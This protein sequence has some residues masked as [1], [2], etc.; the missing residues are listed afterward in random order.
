MNV[1]STSEAGGRPRLRLEHIADWDARIVDAKYSPKE[2]C[3]QCG[4]SMRHMQRFMM[5][6]FKIGL[7]AFVNAL[8][9]SKAHNLLKAG[10]SIK[11]TAIGLG[12]KQTSHF[13]R[14][15]KQHFAAKAST[16]LLNAK[17]PGA[18]NDGQMELDFL[19]ATPQP[20]RRKKAPAKKTK[21][22]A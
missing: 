5:K 13:C 11:E 21:A 6:R 3:A 8:R 4:F 10:F 22:R 19:R 7:R 18:A 16:V 9:M 15:F 20:K 17:G 1:D 14:S 12:F 2:L